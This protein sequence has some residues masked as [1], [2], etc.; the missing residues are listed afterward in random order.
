M[1]KH[2][3]SYVPAFVVA[4]T[5]GIVLTFLLYQTTLRLYVAPDVPEVFRPVTSNGL[6]FCKDTDCS[7][8]SKGP[9]QR[10]APVTILNGICSASKTSLQAVTIV[11]F[12]EAKVDTIVARNVVISP[13]PDSNAAISPLPRPLNPGCTATDPVSG[14]MPNVPDGFWHLY[15][16]ITVMGSQA[17]QMQRLVITSGEIEVRGGSN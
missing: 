14:I 7:V 9:F 12:E 13:K 11:G 5:L 2:I 10:G 8:E 1:V 3:A 17:G 15:V 6:K 4:V 16:T